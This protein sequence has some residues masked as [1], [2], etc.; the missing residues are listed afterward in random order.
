MIVIN[1]LGITYPTPIDE[2]KQENDAAQW[3]SKG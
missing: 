1:G 2:M 3:G